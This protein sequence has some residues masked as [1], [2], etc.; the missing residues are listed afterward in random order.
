MAEREF[1]L[2][3]VAPDFGVGDIVGIQKEGKGLLKGAVRSVARRPFAGA[4]VTILKIAVTEGNTSDYRFAGDLAGVTISKANGVQARVRSKPNTA[5]FQGRLLKE[6]RLRTAFNSAADLIALAAMGRNDEFIKMWFGGHNATPTNCREVHRR[7]ALLND[8]VKGL[9]HVYFLC[10]ESETLGAID[11]D[12]RVIYK[13]ATVRIKLGRGLSY[14]RY[15]WGERV[16]T[17]VHELTHWF[18]DT[19]DVELA[20]KDCYGGLCLGLANDPVHY[21]LALNNADN[22]A[23]YICEYRGQGADAALWKYFTAHELAG[24]V[25]FSEDGA[26]RTVDSSLVV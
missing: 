22:W 8:G 1:I 3:A 5:R 14:S 9:A 26:G 20:G 6:G 17:I 12:E 23:Y 18:L 15:S 4:D 25:P 2:E 7:C 21:G 10:G 16:C 11:K 24:R 13:P 19:A